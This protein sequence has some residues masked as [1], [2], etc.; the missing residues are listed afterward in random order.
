MAAENDTAF[1]SRFLLFIAFDGVVL[2]RL[3]AANITPAQ[4]VRHQ[5]K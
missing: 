4:L 5:H 3:D 2:F 1:Y